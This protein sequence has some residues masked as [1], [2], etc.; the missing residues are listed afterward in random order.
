MKCAYSWACI[1]VYVHLLYIS[2]HIWIKLLVESSFLSVKN[3]R[4]FL[5]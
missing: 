5:I 4:E 3:N 2:T 1:S